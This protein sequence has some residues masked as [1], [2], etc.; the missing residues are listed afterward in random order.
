[1]SDLDVLKEKAGEYAPRTKRCVEIALA[2]VQADASLRMPFTDA[3]RKNGFADWLLERR[4]T[5][6]PKIA[7]E[8]RRQMPEFANK[9]EDPE[10]TEFLSGT[11]WPEVELLLK[12]MAVR[13]NAA[14]WALGKIG[15]AV[16]LELPVF[17]GSHWIVGLGLQNYGS[18]LGQIA[19]DESGSILP[20]LTTTKH[21][22][23]EKIHAKSVP[24]PAAAAR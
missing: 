11:I 18:K 15:D 20:E 17:N 7:D 5:Y 2:T 4:T 8:V 10:F 12:T 19:L 6:L 9:T 22:L 24:S 23:L 1:M 13:A 16:I 21:E 3:A 14:R